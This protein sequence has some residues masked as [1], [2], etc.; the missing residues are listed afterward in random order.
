MSARG[1]GRVRFR[2]RFFAR[3]LRSILR[4]GGIHAELGPALEL[5]RFRPRLPPI[6]VHAGVG[7]DGVGQEVGDSY[8][9]FVD[10]R[11][12]LLLPPYLYPTTLEA[13]IAGAVAVVIPPRTTADARLRFE[14]EP[15]TLK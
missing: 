13:L 15:W 9:Y 10:I 6:V 4:R 14:E 1:R 2:L 5:C 7:Q 11:C 12:A 3:L 8:P